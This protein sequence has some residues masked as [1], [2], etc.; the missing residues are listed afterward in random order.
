MIPTERFAP[1]PTGRLHLGHAYSALLAHDRARA[2]GGRFLLR[3][4]DLDRGRV[5]E[6]YAAGIVED[7]AW[8]GLTW[9]EPVLRQSNRLPAYDAALG[10]LRSAGLLYACHCSRRDIAEA[11][12]APQEGALHGPDGPVYPGTC[13]GRDPAEAGAALRLDLRRALDRLGHAPGFTEI[14]AG[15]E[16]ETGPQPGD[17]DALLRGTGDIVLR[18]R[19]GVPAYHLAAVVD[20]AWQ[21]VSHVTRGCDLFAATGVQR[22]LQALLGLPAP[23]YRHHRLI[24]DETGKRLA[25]RDDA[26]ALATLRAEGASPADLRRMVGLG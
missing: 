23:V 7:L 19:D 16:G 4:E 22:V 26:R 15:P 9:A 1:S 14:G 12:G 2:A 13:R 3:L 25:K 21:G 18:R 8:L 20:D 6:A 11:A 5:R 17:G 10:A 24:R